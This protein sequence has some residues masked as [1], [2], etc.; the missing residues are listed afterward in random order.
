[1]PSKRRYMLSDF[2]FELPDEL[3]AQFPVKQREESR[4]LI[5]NRESGEFDHRVFRQIDE[6][7]RVGDLLVLNDARV[8]PARIFFRRETG[9]L[10][11]IILIRQFD[12][13]IWLAL[14]NKTKRLRENE[15]L[16]AILDPS[17][18]IEIVERMAEGILFGTNTTFDFDILNRIGE[19]PLPPYIKRG[20][21]E[22][23]AER[24][25]TVFAVA[26]GAIASPTAGLHFS[27][28]LISKLKRMGVR[29]AYLT[30]Y[31]SWGTFQPVRHEDLSKHKMHSE[32]FTLDENTAGEI[33]RAR[34]EDRR[35]IAVGTTVL[36]VL[37]STF[38]NG[39]NVPAHGETDIFIYPPYEIK[40]VDALITNFHT[41]YSTLLML[42][43]AFAGY[44]KIMNAY[45]IAVKERYRFYS[46]GDAMLIL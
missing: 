4:L 35:V 40:S 29:I 1:M 8:I 27:D 24:Y 22:I 42:V 2:S 12:E 31:V 34:E 38:K 46:Y 7:L 41:P 10:I 20:I 17:I 33:N 32:Q 9:G 11:E 26:D 16:K 37:E 15:V 5:L 44:K 21:S 39:I 28:E 45:Q 36:R 13:R 25:Q 43:S 19:Y 3:I 23:D 14:T 30:L 6:Y 18:E